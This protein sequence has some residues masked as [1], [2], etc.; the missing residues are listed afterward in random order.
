[1]VKAVH[2]YLDSDTQSEYKL[3]GMVTGAQRPG[4]N[5][6]VSHYYIY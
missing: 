1:M 3:K 2:K 5:V 6:N 4:W